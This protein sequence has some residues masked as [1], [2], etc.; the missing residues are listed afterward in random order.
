MRSSSLPVLLAGAFPLIVACSGSVGTIAPPVP[1]GPAAAPPT[2][3]AAPVAPATTPAREFPAEVLDLADWSLTLPTG[4][5]GSPDEIRQPELATYR[6]AWFRVDD[7]GTAVAFTANAGGATTE[8]SRYPRSELREWSDGERAAWSNTS[9]V[10]VLS[11][12]QAVTALPTAKPDV[13]TAQIHDD[14]DDVVEIRLE[15]SRLL[16]EYDDGDGSVELDPDY[17]LGTPYDLEIVAADGR[18]RVSYN[19]VQT[20]DLPL[21][22]DDWYFKVGSYVQSSP[23]RGEEPDAVGTVVVT[24]LRVTHEP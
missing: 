4:E 8:N 12:R 14:E 17:R 19:G 5:E 24:G 21:S 22:G 16:A 2:P 15:G 23:E 6:D 1:A 20:A 11:V 9:G 18:V 10:H 13:V 7:T 3:T